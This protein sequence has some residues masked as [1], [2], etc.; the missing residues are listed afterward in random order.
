MEF[1]ITQKHYK[2]SRR[3]IKKLGTEIKA[4]GIECLFSVIGGGDYRFLIVLCTFI[5]DMGA[6][7]GQFFE[8]LNDKRNTS[9][10]QTTNLAFFGY[11]F[12]ESFVSQRRKQKFICKQFHK[13]NFIGIAVI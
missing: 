8:Y 6:T 9:N 5:L 3:V 12:W 10:V 11:A 4:T 2:E 13:R 1:S 7:S